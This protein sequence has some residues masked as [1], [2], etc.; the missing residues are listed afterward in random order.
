ML[1]LEEKHVH[2]NKWKALKYLMQFALCLQVRKIISY[3]GFYI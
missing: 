2:T 3:A 1:K